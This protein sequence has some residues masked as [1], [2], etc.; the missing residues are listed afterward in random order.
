[1][2]PPP[3]A[4]PVNNLGDASVIELAAT[5]IDDS[6]I[7]TTVVSHIADS[8]GKSTAPFIP[9]LGAWLKPLNLT[10]GLES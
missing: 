6:M 7:P 5:E 10:L 4:V 9:S 1:M 3:I 2:N 8:I